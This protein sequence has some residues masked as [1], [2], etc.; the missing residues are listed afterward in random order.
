M[1][2]PGGQHWQDPAPP[3]PESARVENTWA[4]GGAICIPRIW[5]KQDQTLSSWRAAYSCVCSGRTDL[6][7]VLALVEAHLVRRRYAACGSFTHSILR[8]RSEIKLT[9]GNSQN[10]RPLLANW[11]Q[12]V[13]SPHHS[14]GF[15]RSHN[16]GQS[17]SPPLFHT[18]VFPWCNWMCA[19]DRSTSSTT[20]RTSATRVGLQ[21][22]SWYARTCSLSLN[23]P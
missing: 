2:Q 7:Q 3:P 18:C 22:S 8:K 13:T 19:W 5:S 20:P 17:S 10:L 11:K 16:P 4:I 23:L 1:R 6:N 21:T 12:R 14:V 15:C 9:D